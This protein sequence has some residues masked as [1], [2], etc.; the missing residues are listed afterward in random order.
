[1]I[2]WI[3]AKQ[4]TQSQYLWAKCRWTTGIILQ[5]CGLP[6]TLYSEF[7]TGPFSK[8]YLSKRVELL[9]VWLSEAPQADRSLLACLMGFQ[10]GKKTRKEKRKSAMTYFT[11]YATLQPWKI[12]ASFPLLTGCNNIQPE[13]GKSV[14]HYV[15]IWNQ[16]YWCEKKITS[17]N[18]SEEYINQ[19]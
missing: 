9:H 5:L 3:M 18:C 7:Q 15:R 11:T 2:N 6:L 8:Y 14:L 19:S 10:R 16:T 4:D 1:M 13:S 17:F 12:Q